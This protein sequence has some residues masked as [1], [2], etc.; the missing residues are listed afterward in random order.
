[1][2][3]PASVSDHQHERHAG[4]ERHPTYRISGLKHAGVLDHHN[5][6]L[7]ADPE[8]GRD[9][10]G[11]TLTAHRNETDRVIISQE[12]VHEVGLAV[13]EPDGVGDPMFVEGFDDGR[14]ADSG[15]VVGVR[16]MILLGR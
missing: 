8:P 6:L 16:H 2:P 15:G 12:D 14:S 1:M 7:P 9:S 13:R 5:R 10:H 11:L 4:V 3:S